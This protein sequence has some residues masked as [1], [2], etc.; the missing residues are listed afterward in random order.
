MRLPSVVLAL[1]A[2]ALSAN[3]PFAR[4]DGLESE[5]LPP[6][7]EPVSNNA[8][9]LLGDGDHYRLYSLLGLA[10]GKTWRDVG[11][12]AFVFDSGAAAWAPLEPVPGRAGRLAATAVA[13]GGNVYAFGGYTVAADG[14]ESSTAA[15]HRLQG[16][17]GRWQHFTDMPV[18]VDDAV[19]LV[20]RD[21]YVYLV[22]GWHDLGNVNLVQLLDTRSG[23][24]LQ[25]TPW[26]GAPV[27]GH[28]GA[29]SKNRLLVCDGVR[30]EYPAGDTPR[31]FVPS[32]ECWSGRIS[33]DDP[34]RIDW[35]PVAP[36]P[37]PARYRMAAGA[38]DAGRVFFAGGTANP[39][40]YDGMGYDGRPSVP[41]AGVFSFDF[42]NRKWA[43][44]GNLPVATMDH[45]GM[46]WN[47]GWFHIIGG[48]RAGQKVSGEVFRFRPAGA[49]ACRAEQR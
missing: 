14:S 47:D 5:P 6:L 31:R 32:A 38:D 42:S 48:M 23:T 45:R 29:I 26:P 46:P 11:S 34:R 19:A 2:G 7:P 22:S 30:V 33:A 21:R 18:P 43:C 9:T 41:E 24:W 3:S 1:L 4:G 8:V 49:R 40:N 25:A 20:Y 13:V 16:G 17:A 15:V 27:F 10:S 44:N 36:H 28:A 12:A 35:R 37:G 39:Y